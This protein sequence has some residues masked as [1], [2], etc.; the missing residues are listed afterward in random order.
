MKNASND[1]KRIRKNG[2]IVV[3]AKSI[4]VMPTVQY[5]SIGKALREVAT[6]GKEIAD[7]VKLL[8][9]K[10]AEKSAEKNAAV[11]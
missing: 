3:L 8:L 11:L 1:M 2:L 9:V 6:Q 10:L 5:E 7:S 4:S